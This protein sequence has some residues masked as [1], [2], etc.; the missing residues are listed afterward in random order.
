MDWIFEIGADL[1]GSPTVTSDDGLLIPVEKQ[2]IE[3][4]GGVFKLN[5]AL[6]PE[7]AVVWYFPVEDKK[8][9]HWEGGIV[10][11]IAV[12]DA[13]V[14]DSSKHI[15]AF[16]GVDGYLYAVD[17]Q[18]IDKET[19]VYGPNNKERYPAPVLVYKE[20]IGGTIST[21]LLVGNRLIAPLDEGLYLYEHDEKLNFTLLDFIQGIPIDATPV[22]HK[23]RLYIA[24]LDGYLYCFGEK[25]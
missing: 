16:I 23:G 4:K 8:W 21:P 22:C 24:S 25:K 11:S 2:Y 1:N 15:A 10:G 12:N 7:E 6:P 17:H 13:Y 14:S 5:P 3:G 20:H 18:N 9:F 19:D